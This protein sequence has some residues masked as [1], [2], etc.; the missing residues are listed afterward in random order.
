M[1]VLRIED[2]MSIS[3]LKLKGG[4]PSKTYKATTCSFARMIPLPGQPKSITNGMTCT[5]SRLAYTI[6]K[7]AG[8]HPESIKILK[9]GPSALSRTIIIGTKKELPIYKACLGVCQEKPKN[10][11]LVKLL[12]NILFTI[13]K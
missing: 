11:K 3:S 2:P 7:P 4:S 10:I 9:F 12:S 5:K 6:Q 1:S 8:E 13:T